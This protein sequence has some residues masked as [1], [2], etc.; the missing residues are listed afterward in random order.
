MTDVHGN[1]DCLN[2]VLA[3][4]LPLRPSDQIFFLGDSVDRGPDSF[5]VIEVL[6]GLSERFPGQITCLTGNHELM[7][8][9]GAGVVQMP[10]YIPTWLQTGGVNTVRSYCIQAGVE[11]YQSFPL[12][13]LQG[14]IPAKHIS[15]LLETSRFCETDD[16]IFVHA[17]CD[18]FQPLEDQSNDILLW[19]KSLYK[20]AINSIINKTTIP[21]SKTV[22]T[23]HN[24]NGPI[25]TSKYMMLDCSR[26]GAL[27]CVELNSMQGYLAYPQRKRMLQFEVKETTSIP[28]YIIREL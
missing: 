5:Q 21:W 22:I 16:Y 18:P 11:D 15:F 3:R 2:Q 6:I 1:Y 25:I 17:G 7:L 24:Y 4:I 8:L 27:A 12:H 23:G 20:F 26:Q 13:R 10:M 28:Q 9:A 14:I 19:D